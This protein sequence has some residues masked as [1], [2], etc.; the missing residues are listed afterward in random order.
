MDSEQLSDYTTWRWLWAHAA[1]QIVAT[2]TLP[3]NYE[4]VEIG[5]GA[6]VRSYGGEPVLL[7]HPSGAGHKSGDLSITVAGQPASAIPREGR[8]YADYVE[9]VAAVVEQT[10]QDCYASSPTAGAKA[11]DG[12]FAH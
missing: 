8:A 7:L 3:A 11:T 1:R 12:P 2:L 9:R 6:G 4:R 10:L 5:Y